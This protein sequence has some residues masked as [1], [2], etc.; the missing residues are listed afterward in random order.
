[1]F[2]DEAIIRAKAGDGGKGSASFRREKFIPRGGPDGGDGGKGGDVWAVGDE[3][4]SD[5]SKYSYTPNIFAGNGAKGAGRLK[6][7]ASGA[8]AELKVPPGTIIYDSETGAL[9]AE[10]LEHKERVLLLRGGSGGLGNAHFKSST[11]R[12][13]RQFTE[14]TEGESGAFKRNR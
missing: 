8:D 1:M 13:P 3:N 11:N 4:L 9:V 10:I 14:G 5:L 7:G 2:V 6:T 12:A